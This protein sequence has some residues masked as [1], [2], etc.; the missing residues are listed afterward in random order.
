MA[1]VDI[2]NTF[3]VP[4]RSK[5][6]SKVWDFNLFYSDEDWKELLSVMGRR[7]LFKKHFKKLRNELNQLVRIL[8]LIKHA[9]FAPYYHLI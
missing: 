9:K 8:Y 3:Y 7:N 4:I 2:L 6:I 5:D 1:A